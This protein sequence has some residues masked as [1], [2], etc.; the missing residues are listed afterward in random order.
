MKTNGAGETIFGFGTAVESNKFFK[1]LRLPGFA[2]CP[3]LDSLLRVSCLY[4]QTISCILKKNL[5][6]EQTF[7]FPTTKKK[8]QGD[9]ENR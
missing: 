2:R 9:L 6:N 7:H 8:A 5:I 1:L 3:K 4:N